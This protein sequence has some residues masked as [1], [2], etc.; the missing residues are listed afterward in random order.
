MNEGN[1]K[2]KDLM[3]EEVEETKSEEKRVK[4]EGRERERRTTRQLMNM[5][6]RG[7]ESVTKEYEK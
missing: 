1:E 6:E 5:A 4:E 2:Q 3:I 7:R